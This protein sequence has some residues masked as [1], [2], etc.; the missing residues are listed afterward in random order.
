MPQHRLFVLKLLVS[1]TK[2]PLA[3]ISVLANSS[4]F[5]KSMFRPLAQSD[6]FLGRRYDEA[7]FPFPVR[8]LRWRY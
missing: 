2:M 4:F 1:S 8:L 7:I 5:V 6:V 3:H